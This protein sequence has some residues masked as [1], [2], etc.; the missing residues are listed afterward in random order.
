MEEPHPSVVAAARRGEQVAFEQLVRIYQAD[1]WRLCHHLLGDRSAADD[2]TQEAFLR[3]Y[4][5]VPKFK[6]GSKFSTWLFSIAR[7]C[8]LDEMRRV[9]RLRRLSEAVKAQPEPSPPR[10]EAGLEVREAVCGLAMDLREP[11]VMIDVLGLSYAEVGEA[12]SLPVGTV[13]SRVHRARSALADAL[14]D[15]LE[16]SSEA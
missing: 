15:Y 3:A 2:A 11:L 16:R 14:T 1:I 5:F 9:G 13:K 8:C 7:N 4:R 12:L 10:S 6:G